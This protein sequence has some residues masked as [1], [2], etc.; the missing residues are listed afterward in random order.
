MP[1]ETRVA[2]IGAGLG[3]M[4]AAAFLQRAGFDARIYEQAPAFSCLGAGIILSPNVAKVFKN[5]G[6]LQS[7]IAAGIEA[8]WYISRA[9]DTGQTLYRIDFDA[10]TEERYGGVYLN[11][12]RGALLA[13]MHS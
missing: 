12:H 2:I 1:P 8:D 5:L 3:G 6:L 13:V 9:W 7:L 10:A 4:T 11:V